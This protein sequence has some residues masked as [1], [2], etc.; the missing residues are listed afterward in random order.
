MVINKHPTA[1]LSGSIA[2]GGFTPA[3]VAAVYSYGITQDNAAR[4]GVGSVDIAQSSINNASSSFT[5]SFPPYSVTVL[6]LDPPVSITTTFA[7][8]R[9]H[10]KIQPIRRRP[11]PPVAALPAI[12]GRLAPA[13]CR[14]A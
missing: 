11:S 2:L 4:T 7:T 8:A 3:A 10:R 5:Y 9:R 12:L 14:P 1:T 6:S 13:R